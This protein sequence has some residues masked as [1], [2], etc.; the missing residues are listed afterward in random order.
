MRDGEV[1][2][3]RCPRRARQERM[4]AACSPQTVCGSGNERQHALREA[5][6]P[7][8]RC[9]MSSSGSQS[10]MSGGSRKLWRRSGLRKSRAMAHLAHRAHMESATGRELNRQF[11]PNPAHSPHLLNNSLYGGKFG[12]ISKQ[13]TARSKKLRRLELLQAPIVNRNAWKVVPI[14]ERA[15]QYANGRLSKDVDRPSDVSRS[16][17]ATPR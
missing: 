17:I 8:P 10:C 14:P 7:K 5:H 6:T 15:G 1:I 11:D 16:W 4:T 9:T 2:G 3:G 13:S 12:A